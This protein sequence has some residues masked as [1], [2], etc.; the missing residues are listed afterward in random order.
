IGQISD[1]LRDEIEKNN[2]ILTKT[3]A[4][5]I[6]H[7]DFHIKNVV[8]QSYDNIYRIGGLEFISSIP[9]TNLI[10]MLIPAPPEDI[11]KAASQ[12]RYRD[13]V[14]VTIMLHREK[15]TDNTWIYL[16]EKKIPMGRIHEPRN[17][18]PNAAPKG[19]THLVSEYFCFR[20]DKI[21]NLSEENLTSLTVEHLEEL[22][23]INSSEV[24]DS[25]VVRATNAYPVFEVG[26]WD[27]YHKIL[28]YLKRFKNL[29][30]I[31]R[32]GMFKYYN[33]DH[34]MESGINVAEDILRRQL[35]ERKRHIYL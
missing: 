22:G 9:L 16:P 32:G 7:E 5:R 30:I 14:V 33:M 12:L 19:Q 15:V 6:D 27:H 24:I 23:F 26:Y 3:K 18:Y 2:P 1:R 31:G 34:A 20:G 11:L 29:H 4:T 13:I 28:K 17:W 8:G 35:T 10:Q 25:C 21:W